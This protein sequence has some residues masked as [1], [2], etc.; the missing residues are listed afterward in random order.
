M[1]RWSGSSWMH[2][3]IELRFVE[4]YRRGVK[5]RDGDRRNAGFR[6]AEMSGVEIVAPR[7]VV[8]EFAA[9]SLCACCVSSVFGN[10]QEMEA[11]DLSF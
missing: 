11:R 6:I 4:R 2:A 9:V 1:G 3:R 7:V 10:L 5:G 8:R